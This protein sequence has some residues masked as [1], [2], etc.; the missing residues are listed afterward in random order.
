MIF[1]ILLVLLVT[2]FA[3]TTI[4]TTQ[5]AKENKYDVTDVVMENAAHGEDT[6]DE[7]EDYPSVGE[8]SDEL[9][10]VAFE[11]ADEQRDLDLTFEGT[12]I[13]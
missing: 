5:F 4:S 13:D 8:D 6:E 2:C 12:E 11:H 1:N 9:D 10:P 3:T 7:D